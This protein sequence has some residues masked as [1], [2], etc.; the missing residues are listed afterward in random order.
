[1]EHQ[2]RLLGIDADPRQLDA[3]AAV[4]AP[5][6][7]I[8]TGHYADA[9]DERTREMALERIAQAVSYGRRLGLQ[10]HA[11]YGLDYHNVQAIVGIDG[12][13]ELNI[14][15]AIICRALFT[16]LERAVRE[17]KSLLNPV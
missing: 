14:G 11:G 5:V 16:G 6:V 2:D 3:A 13:R 8:H 12:I 17:M 7:E 1:M 15:H 10:V 9:H 4:G